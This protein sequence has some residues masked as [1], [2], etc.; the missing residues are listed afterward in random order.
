MPDLDT[1][2]T[3]TAIVAI[4]VAWGDLRR[5]VRGLADEVRQQNGRIGKVEEKTVELA[6]TV[7]LVRGFLK[8]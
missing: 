6:E 7:G 3:L 2:L 1:G 4:A 8:L 5:N